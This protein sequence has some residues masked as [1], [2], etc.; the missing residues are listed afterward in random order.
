MTVLAPDR[1]KGSCRSRVPV[2]KPSRARR[3]MAPS[4]RATNCPAHSIPQEEVHQQAFFTGSD[5]G[6]MKFVRSVVVATSRGAVDARNE[7]RSIEVSDPVQSQ[8]PDGGACGRCGG[9]YRVHSRPG[10]RINDP[11]GRRP[12][13]RRRGVPERGAQKFRADP[14]SAPAWRPGPG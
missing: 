8:V 2:L 7:E 10:H 1:E 14:C 3:S 13:P 6:P 4:F 5:T 11:L 9:H 12:V